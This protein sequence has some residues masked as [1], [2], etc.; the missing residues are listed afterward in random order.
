MK[1]E[2]VVILGASDK[3][4]KY[5]YKAMKML[6]EN[7]HEVFLVHPSLESI[8]GHKVYKYL[9]DIKEKIDTLTM[10]VNAK[11]SSSLE[12]EILRLKP[13]RVIFNPGAE[14]EELRGK[15]ARASVAAEEACTLV[16]LTTGQY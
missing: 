7:G 10:Y 8:E 11:I 2:K 4:D 9:G 16:L 13:A 14:N 6:L 15:L 1:S 5:S 3:S 12:G